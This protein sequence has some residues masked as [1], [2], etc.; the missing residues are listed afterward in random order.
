MVGLANRIN[1]IAQFGRDSFTQG[2]TSIPNLLLRTYKSIGLTDIELVVLFHLVYFRLAEKNSFPTLEKFAHLMS[3]PVEE[4]ESCLNQLMEKKIISIDKRIDLDTLEFIEIYNLEGL[5]D[6]L[7]EVWAIER[8]ND[9]E[10]QQRALKR[11]QEKSFTAN[12]DHSRTVKGANINTIS[13]TTAMVYNAF[14]SEFGR[15]LSPMEGE[16]IF[17]WCDQFPV[18]LVI[19]ALRISVI[20]GTCN[21]RY[22][23]RILQDWERKNI[24]SI[25]QVRELE[26][27]YTKKKAY[28]ARKRERTLRSNRTDLTKP[29]KDDKYRDLYSI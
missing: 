27:A 16:L 12:L 7:S 13:E 26:E 3:T 29:V 23:E 6:K 5:F 15:P 20:Q 17:S 11:K 22:I 1:L 28:S 9:F 4:I 18:E 25:R 21:L 19:E 10:E 24:H 8:N 2:Y 14:E